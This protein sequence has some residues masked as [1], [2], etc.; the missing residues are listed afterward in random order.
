MDKFHDQLIGATELVHV[1]KRQ[2][3]ENAK[4]TEDAK[5]LL[6]TVVTLL[7][8]P[9]TDPS[10]GLNVRVDRLEQKGKFTQTFV[11]LVITAGLG[12]LAQWWATYK[13]H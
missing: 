12:G 7:Q 13:A 10:K 4:L 5:K 8:G 11:W 2:T 6:E 1:V 9:A 3:E